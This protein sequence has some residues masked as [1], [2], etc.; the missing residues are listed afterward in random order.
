[1]LTY[2]A[3]SGLLL[4]LRKVAFENLRKRE[5]SMIKVLRWLRSTGG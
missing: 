3:L 1:M 4:A 5:D 2:F